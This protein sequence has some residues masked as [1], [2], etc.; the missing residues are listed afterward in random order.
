MR[1]CVNESCVEDL[2]CKGFDQFVANFRK[3][4]VLLFKRL[5]VAYFD[6]VDELGS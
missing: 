4:I 5:Y 3:G 1:I 6:T 2:L